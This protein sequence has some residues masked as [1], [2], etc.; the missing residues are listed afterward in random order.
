MFNIQLYSVAPKIPVEL[1]FLEELSYDL[2]WCWHREALELF[3]K[4]DFP[5][6]EFFPPRENDADRDLCAPRDF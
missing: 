2:W 5:L 1:K 6:D 4:I 3:R